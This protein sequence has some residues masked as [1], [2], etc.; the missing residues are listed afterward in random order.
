[1]TDRRK[2]TGEKRKILYGDYVKRCFRNLSYLTYREQLDHKKVMQKTCVHL[3]W[4]I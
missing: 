2:S 1:M 3:D 4:E